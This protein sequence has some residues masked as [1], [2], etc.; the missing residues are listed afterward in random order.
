MK[1][2]GRF[3]PPVTLD[4]SSACNFKKNDNGYGGVLSFVLKNAPKKTY[5]FYDKIAFSKGPNLG[6]TYSLCCPFVML[7]HYNELEWAEKMGASRWL[8]RLSIGLEPPENLIDRLN[9][10][11]G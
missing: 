4:N 2:N 7:A 9:Y 11:L 5:D 6:A 1:S 8:I 3:K 10:A